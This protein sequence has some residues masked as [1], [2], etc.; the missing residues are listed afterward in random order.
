[1][2]KL[3]KSIFG[4]KQNAKSIASAIEIKEMPASDWWK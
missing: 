2:I 3:I 1:M 4:Q